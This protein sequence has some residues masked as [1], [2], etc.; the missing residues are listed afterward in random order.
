[1]NAIPQQALQL[2]D[3]HLPGTPG[4]WPPAPGWWIVAVLVAAL[5]AWAG[6]SALRWYR[7][8]R[9]RR[10][11]VALVASLEV[12]LLSEP[13]PV[14][15]AGISALLRRLALM[16]FSRGRV[17]ALTGD[18]WLRFLDE[19]GGDGRFAGGPGQVL[20]AGPYQRALPR[21][22]DAAGLASLVREWA[23]KN[24]GGAK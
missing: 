9:T 23:T 7:I 4:F 8:R 15:L 3:I 2:R 18:A 10:R 19:S 5:L 22:V 16:R 6:A 11:I 20:A 24:A 14:V 21:D 13:T 12:A 17:A 1:M